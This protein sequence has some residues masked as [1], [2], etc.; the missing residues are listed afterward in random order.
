M[1]LVYEEYVLREQGGDAPDPDS[2]CDRYEPWRDSVA[3]QLRF[4]R[5]LSQISGASSIETKFPAPGDLFST[6]RLR[7]V[8][9]Q[10][11]S[12]RVYLAMDELLGDRQVALKVSADR[13]DEPTIQGR[14]DHAH[15]VPV[16]SVY[17]DMQTGLRGLS[18]PYREG[19][20]LDRAIKKINPASRP[21]H[22]S[23]IRDAIRPEPGAAASGAEECNGWVGFPSRGTYAEGVAWVVSVIARALAYAHG[24]DVLHRDVKPA[25]LLLTH[26][27]GPQLL[28]FNLAH[29]TQLVER[30]EEALR[31]GTLP[32][33]AP[34]QLDAFR[35]P[36][37]WKGVGAAADIYS[38][39]LL[40]REMLTGKKP[41]A[42]R[43][44]IPL[45]WAIRDLMD[46]R[47]ASLG[48]V[49]TLN[50]DV[51]HALDAILRRCLANRPADR[52]GTAHDLAEDLRLFVEHRPLRFAENPSRAERARN[53]FQR[54]GKGLLD[55][56]G[57]LGLIAGSLS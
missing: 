1:S 5:E 16:L 44:D 23:A 57:G 39:G 12:A 48:S 29:S 42:P 41:D 19:L 2:F 36:E 43:Q 31:G 35:D 51:P 32:Y 18:M 25:N 22:A 6:F 21:K 10:G 17:T 30:A 38:L 24:K 11:G 49:R 28:D 27:E 53:W 54:S 33:M 45:P 52:Y 34:E 4:H 7:S 50:P 3:S 20:P 46:R 56:R 55:W 26:R 40:L 37:M 14:L 47:L 13:S 9:G 8:L 15:I